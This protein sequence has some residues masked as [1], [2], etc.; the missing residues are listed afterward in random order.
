MKIEKE[1]TSDQCQELILSP[2]LD[3]VGYYPGCLLDNYLLYNWDTEKYVII[4]EKY[5]NE[6]SNTL[7]ATETDDEK[8][9]DNFFKVQDEILANSE[10][11]Y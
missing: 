4:Q 10:L 9:V 1:I 3:Q 6:W 5:L 7:I 8:L 2:D 11:S